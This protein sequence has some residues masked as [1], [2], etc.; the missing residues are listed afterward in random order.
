MKSLLNLMSI[1]TEPIVEQLTLNE[2]DLVRF[3]GQFYIFKDGN[4][5]A[6]NDNLSKIDILKPVNLKYIGSIS[7]SESKE[8]FQTLK[9]LK[10]DY[11][12]LKRLRLLE[13]QK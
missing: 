9:E 8:Y 11:E 2:Q 10:D 7:K 5:Y 13:D 12:S 3:D 4:V 6:I 1:N